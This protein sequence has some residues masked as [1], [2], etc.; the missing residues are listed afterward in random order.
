[1]FVL[2]VG[3]YSVAAYSTLRRALAGLAVTAAGA[4]V[5][6]LANHDIMTGNTGNLAL[7]LT[8]QVSALGLR[9]RDGYHPGELPA[10]PWTDHLTRPAGH[11]C[12]Y[13]PVQLGPDGH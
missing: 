2:G 3:S 5:Y 6:G 4:T 7:T 10:N 9:V 1:M 13:L 12:D 11:G 8:C